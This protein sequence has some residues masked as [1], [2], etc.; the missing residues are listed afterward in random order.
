MGAPTSFEAAGGRP[1]LA[2][3]RPAKAPI[4]SAGNVLMEN[5][6]SGVLATLQKYKMVSPRE[7]ILVACSGGADSVA[8]LL[9]LN[10]LAPLLKIRLTVLHFDH[11]LRK[12]SAQDL[13]F[14]KGLARRRR[15]PFYSARRKKVEPLLKKNLS[16]EEAARE[17]RYLFFKT[18]AKKTGVRKIALGHHRDD[19]AETVLM[20]LIQGTGLRGLQGMRPVMKKDGLILVRPL[21]E[22]GRAEL[23]EFLKGRSISFRKDPTNRSP[24]FLRNRIRHRLLPLM[25]REFNP[26]IRESLIRLA[27]TTLAESQGLDVWTRKNWRT[28]IRSRKNGT[29]QLRRGTFLSLPDALQFRVL[30]QVLHWADPQ[31]GLDFKSWEALA[32]GLRKGRYRVNLPRNLDLCLTS[33]T[34]SIQKGT[35]DSPP[36]RQL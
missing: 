17:A 12:E 6:L 19:Q 27:R 1:E 22:V 32:G 24:R 20:R 8:L 10:E 15:L 11:G 36:P 31:S 33:K 5:I 25:E 2:A 28:F 7:K 3:K 34:L 23:R 4:P 13:K 29:V 30:D 14:V 16:P 9:I 18:I 21:M 35:L 26:R